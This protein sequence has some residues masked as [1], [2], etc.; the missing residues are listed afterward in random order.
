MPNAGYSTAVSFSTDDSSYNAIDGIK[1]FSGDL[2]ADELDTTDFSDTQWRTRIQ[3]LKSGSFT[4]D[5]DYEPSDTAQ[6][7]LKTLFTS[8]ATGYIK[9]LFDGTNGYK[10]AVKVMSYSPGSAVDGL[11]SFSCNLS[12]VAAPTFLP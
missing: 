7:A 6:T 3:G 12:S 1:N 10:C 8:G 2:T 9:V 11:A 4:I 5:G